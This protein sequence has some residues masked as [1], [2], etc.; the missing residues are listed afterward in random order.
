MNNFFK[1]QERKTNVKTEFIAGLTTFLA[2]AYILFVNPNQLATEWNVANGLSWGSV[3]TATAIAAIVGT[4]IM[5]LMAN[6]P[7]ALAPGMGMNSF[8][9]F[10]ITAP[11]AY[12]FSWQLGFASIFISG[13][14]CV[15]I[16]LS[17]IREKIIN[18]IPQDLKYAVGAGIGLFIAYVGLKNSG[19][20]TFLT[21]T[22][23]VTTPD[24]VVPMMGDLSN[25]LILLAVIGLIIT[26]ILYVLKVPAAVFLGIVA[27]S[28]IGIIWRAIL[29][30][31][32]ALTDV[33]AFGLPKL[34][35][36]VAQ[37]PEAPKFGAFLSGFGDYNWGDLSSI[38][39]FAVVVFSLVFI[40]F[41]DTA[42]TL[43]TV[44][45][46]CGMINEKG[47]LEGSGGALI[48]DSTATVVG[49]VVGT[50]STTSY[51]ESLAGVEVGG[52]TGLTAVFTAIFFFIAM[53]FSPIL[54][55]V[56]APVTAP[57]LIFVGVLM[58]SQLGKINWGNLAVAIPA[59]FIIISMP[60]TYS[61]ATGIAVGFLFYPITMIASKRHKEV[62]KIMYILSAVFLLYFVVISI[63]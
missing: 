8:F 51:I 58:A 49:A 60:L 42:G 21:N 25:P 20:I 36:S 28:V 7:V 23:G 41:F 11:F 19:I 59:F 50:S 16:A 14:V 47:E 26:V 34:P 22:Q 37:L 9:A 57:A 56:T 43:V 35:T 30:G 38:F 24:S 32:G 5:G 44:G 10:T 4:L 48:A 62:D 15:L 1:L 53:F 61:I 13:V 17:G 6:Y 55:V 63:W 40:D 3:F 27:T 45:S 46:R 33:L 2:M 52:R 18:A 54:S 12:A 31:N 29:K 39:T